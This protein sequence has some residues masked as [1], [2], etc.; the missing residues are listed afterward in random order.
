MLAAFAGV[1]IV[2]A[3]EAVQRQLDA[4]IGHHR[5]HTFGDV[6]VGGIIGIDQQGDIH[7][8]TACDLNHTIANGIP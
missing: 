3:R 5:H 1:V 6:L 4:R 8:L 2:F 7:I